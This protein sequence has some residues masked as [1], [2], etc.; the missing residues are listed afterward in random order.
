MESMEDIYQQHAKMLHCFL[1]AKTGQPDLAEE[2]TQETFYQA[3]RKRNTFQGRSSV[4]TW[5]CGIANNVWRNYLRKHR[6]MA[7]LDD[8][9]EQLPV[10]SVEA[11]L[12]QQ[13]DNL[14]VLKALHRLK[15]PMR[16]VVYL[17]LIGNL[18]FRDIGEI[19]E[20][21]EN[22]ARVTYYRA[23]EKISQEVERDE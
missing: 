7:V 1:L 15:E 9:A 10:T 8:L 11:G 5:L 16:E 14:T 6:E 19:M 17:R 21:T 2:L 4:S 22:W 18:S 13:W 12:V 3:L 20:Q 23:R